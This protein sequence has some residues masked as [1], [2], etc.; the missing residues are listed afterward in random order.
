MKDIKITLKFQEAE[1]NGT[2]SLVQIR[3]VARCRQLPVFSPFCGRSLITHF[4]LLFSKG[5]PPSP[6]YSG[7]W[8]PPDSR[9]HPCL[10]LLHFFPYL[11]PFQCLVWFSLNCLY[12]KIFR[13]GSFSPLIPW[14]L[15]TYIF[16][17]D[18]SAYLAFT[19]VGLFFCSHTLPDNTTLMKRYHFVL[20]GSQVNKWHFWLSYKSQNLVLG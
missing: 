7:C 2:D 20:Y 16:L 13:L 11:S 10:N 4:S 5:F 14:Y 19:S 17:F 6:P 3:R 18:F 9:F 8:C 12:L 1:R 15:W